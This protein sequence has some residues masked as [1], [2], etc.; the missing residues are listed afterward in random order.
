MPERPGQSRRGQ[1][2]AA[3]AETQ[4]EPSRA[5]APQAEQRAEA[6]NEGAGST[7]DAEE[8]DARAAQD[9]SYADAAGNRAAPESGLGETEPPVSQRGS[10]E[11]SGSDDLR[12]TLKSQRGAR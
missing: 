8:L 6:S 5:S 1:R 4:D 10:G 7:A 11:Q 3:P 12:R 9:K 2:P